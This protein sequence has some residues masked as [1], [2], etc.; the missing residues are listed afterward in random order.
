MKPRTLAI[1]LLA[2]V[3]SGCQS[4][5]ITD[6]VTGVVF[7]QSTFLMSQ[8]PKDVSFND[9]VRSVTVKTA[10][11]DQTA[12]LKAFTAALSVAP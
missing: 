10:A 2:A 12:V 11:K 8:G 6:P 7:E 9:G 1:I 4:T 5:K 3:L